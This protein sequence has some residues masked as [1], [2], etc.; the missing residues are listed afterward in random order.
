M[1][2][3][4]EVKDSPYAELMLCLPADWNLGKDQ[5]FQTEPE[6]FKDERNYWP[7]RWLKKL[8]RLPHEYNTWL[9]V[10]HTIPNGDPAEAL[11]D[12]LS[13]TGFLICKPVTAPREF[14][15]LRTSPEKTIHFYSVIPLT[16]AEMNFKLEHGVSAL[17]DKLQAH[18]VTELINPDRD[19]VV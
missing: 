1:T 6:A 8:A 2:V 14:Q 15:E 7:V 4:S 12:G 18:G 17:M 16:T 19:S 10:G 3:P 11:A 5:M 13:F 9:G